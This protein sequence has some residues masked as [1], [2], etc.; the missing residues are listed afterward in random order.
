VASNLSGWWEHLNR[1]KVAHIATVDTGLRYLLLNQ[2]LG[3]QCAGYEVYGI[4]APGPEVESIEAA[5][6][7]HIAVSSLTRALRPRADV[8]ALWQLYRI[9]RRERFTIVHT[10]TP[11]AGL[12]GQY[13]AALARVPI[14]VHTIHGLYFPGHMNPKRRWAYV[15]LERLTMLFSHM[16]LSQNPEDIP[17]AIAE[18]ICPPNRIRLIG[19]GIDITAFDPAIQTAE[20]RLCTRTSIGLSPEQKVVG[21]VGR[22]VAEKGYWEMLRAAQIIK[23]KTPNVR[24]LFIGP[25]EPWK[26]DALDPSII[27]NMGLEDVVHFLGHRRDMADL[28]AIMDVLALPSHR[29]GFPRAPMEAAA[30]GVPAVVT[31]IR[32]CRQTVTD[33]LTGYLVPLRD[34]EALAARLL[35]LLQNDTLR[36][37]FGRAARQKAL[38]EFDERLVITR[39]LDTYDQLLT[40]HGKAVLAAGGAYR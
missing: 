6:I 40:Q 33:G 25:V 26:K 15:L 21:M 29:E 2:M 5:G 16:N 24:F 30:M 20:R 8:V 31:D 13:A 9:M 14:R 11:K 22:F 27:A 34:A 3:I 10:H 32:G 35:E 1:A 17:V 19:N 39:I 23:E 37:S 18:K 4:S 12:L 28:Y 36:L 38:T 7:Q